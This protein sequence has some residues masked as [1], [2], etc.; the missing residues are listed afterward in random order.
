MIFQQ[1]SLILVHLDVLFIPR[2]RYVHSLLWLLYFVKEYQ[3]LKLA[4]QI[5]IC[6]MRDTVNV[7]SECLFFGETNESDRTDAMDGFT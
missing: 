5:Y 4:R 2:D 1:T 6:L 3:T 7:E